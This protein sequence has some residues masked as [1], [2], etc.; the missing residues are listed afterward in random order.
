MLEIGVLMQKIEPGAVTNL[1]G[2]RV[3]LARV[4]KDM[5]QLQLAVALNIDY[6]ID[7]NQY[8]ISQLERGSR[9][10]KDYE[11]VAISEV[12]EVDVKWLLFGDK[13]PVM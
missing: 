11:L 3:K 1:C 9:F 2:K 13:V 6:G 7:V 5:N 12:L 4:N 8:S 10:V